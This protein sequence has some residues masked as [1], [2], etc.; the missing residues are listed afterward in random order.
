MLHDRTRA[1]GFSLVELLTVL[2]II[3]LLVAMFAPVIPR[4]RQGAVRVQCASNLRQIGAALIM[5]DQ[6]YKRLPDLEGDRVLFIKRVEEPGEVQVEVKLWAGNVYPDELI[7]MKAATEGVF[8]CPQHSPEG[9]WFGMPS[10][11]PNVFYSAAPITKGKGWYVLAAEV[12]GPMGDGA[13][14]AHRDSVSPGELALRRHGLKSNYLFFDG[15]VDWLLYA[16]ASGPELVN[17][18]TDQRK[19]RPERLE[20]P[21]PVE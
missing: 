4:A 21:V 16:E 8:L 12:D 9:G 5:Y 3:A 20:V 7:K 11:A 10:Y 18:G 2:A 13:H 14:L 1:G 6:T 19:P 17:W 15:H